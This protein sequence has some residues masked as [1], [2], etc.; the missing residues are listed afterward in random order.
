MYRCSLAVLIL[1]FLRALLTV[2]SCLQCDRVV[3]LFH[4]EFLLNQ[5]NLTIQEEIEL[6]AII[7]QAYESFQQSSLPY[8]GVIDPTGLNRARTEY[9]NEFDRF[10]DE[11]RG[12]NIQADMLT[13]VTKGQEILEK[14]LESF[15]N[16]SL[17]PNE[18]GVF[19]QTLMNCDNCEYEERICQPQDPPND[20]ND[21]SL[22][23][24][25]GDQVLLD[26]FLPWHSLVRGAKDYHYSWRNNTYNGTSEED[27]FQMLVVTPEPNIM[28]SQLTMAE[29]GVYRCV[30]QSRGG[31]V[32]SRTHFTL[33]VS[34]EPL[35]TPRP[36]LT[37]PPGPTGPGD[38]VKPKI[39]PHI[40]TT[41]LALVSGLSL[42]G[43]LT[44]VIVLGKVMWRRY[45]TEK[46]RSGHGGG[47]EERMELMTMVAE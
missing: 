35:T 31:T 21:Q 18:C 17:C 33:N 39:P 27:G 16:D 41:S 37:L 29:G 1:V 38:G 15:F 46:W 20:C 6:R 36:F 10:W 32:Y 42:A 8:Q 24:E 28:L 13:I 34:A 43:C 11:D 45:R 5:P 2:L 26:C 30:F 12:D 23:A 44:V 25:E 40:L 19:N 47:E 3:V 22:W 9:H 4:D 7:D 14:H